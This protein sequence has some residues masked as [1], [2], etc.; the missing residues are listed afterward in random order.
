MLLWH[1]VLALP[2]VHLEHES[3]VVQASEN[4]NVVD[5]EADMCTSDADSILST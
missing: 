4:L 3:D 5:K 1:S 2:P